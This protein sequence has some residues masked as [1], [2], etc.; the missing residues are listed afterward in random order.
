MGA[1]R[2]DQLRVPRR[3]G[4]DQPTDR[5][6]RGRAQRPEP[7]ARL[8]SRENGEDVGVN[9]K[10]LDHV[11]YWLADRDAVA[12]FVVRHLGAHVIER[13]DAFTLVGAD[14]RRGKL[15]LFAADGPRERGPL[16]HVALR[17]RSLD[18]ALAGLPGD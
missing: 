13:T 11:A 2:E 17:V 6:V 7:T 5:R 9:P 12:D 10:T 14:A 15:T 4:H 1:V 16:E 8:S 3:D 18:T